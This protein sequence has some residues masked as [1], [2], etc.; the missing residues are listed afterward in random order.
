MTDQINERHKIYDAALKTFG[1]D[2]QLCIAQEEL[3]E[4]IVAISK[5][6]RYQDYA[7][8]VEEIVDVEI[9]IGQLKLCFTEN[10]EGVFNKKINRLKER[11]DGN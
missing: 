9:M 8:M 10:Y 4:L 3:A 11:V 5:W 2:D 6:R 1:L 7:G